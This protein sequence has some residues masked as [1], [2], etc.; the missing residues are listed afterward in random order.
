MRIGRYTVMNNKEQII[1]LLDKI[2]DYKM[3]YVLAYVQGITADEEA[4][5]IFCERMVQNYLN[6]PDPE[7]DEEYTLEECKKEWGID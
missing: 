6:D 2:P 5:D 3:G 1:S 4:D 7:K